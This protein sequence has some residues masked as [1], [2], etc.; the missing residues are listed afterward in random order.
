M[1]DRRAYKLI[2]DVAVLAGDQALLVRYRDV[3]AYDGQRGWFLPDDVLRWLE[4]PDD[5]AARIVR[6]QL[7]LSGTPRLDHVESF[8]NGAW[9]LIFHFRLDLDGPALVTPGENLLAAEWFPTTALP[10]EADMAHDGWA[11]EVLARV[12]AGA[13]A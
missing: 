7:G 8:G 11:G 10:S 3:R 1:A 6:E 5:G 13:P 4:H 2:A 12:S 9:H